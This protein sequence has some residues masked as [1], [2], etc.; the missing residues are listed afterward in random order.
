[1]WNGI[2]VI[3]SAARISAS[4]LLRIYGDRFVQLEWQGGLGYH[5]FVE[6]VEM[7]LRKKRSRLPLVLGGMVVVTILA[8]AGYFLI[9][10]RR[11]QALLANPQEAA[12]VEVANTVKKLSA[13]VELPSGEE[14]TVATVT[15]VEKLRDKP[16]FARAQDG[17]RVVVYTNA[18]RAILFRP[19][20]G[21]IIEMSSLIMPDA[22]NP[23]TTPAASPTPE[24]TVP[25]TVTVLNGTDVKGLASKARET[26]VA[27]P[28]FTVDKTGNTVG[29]NFAQTLVVDVSGTHEED[30]AVLADLI[31]GKVAALPKGE[32]T[33]TTALL[34]ILGT[35]FSGK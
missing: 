11:A 12:K 21:K 4:A 9:R 24:T 23:E 6:L 31:R 35:D 5:G 28:K 2:T 16:F 19:S 10:Y 26:I 33:P 32:E 34:V 3:S 8:L 17:D 25:L 13:L 29:S 20:T 30:A 27:N 15:D 22:T 7:D 14:P 1:M 18:K